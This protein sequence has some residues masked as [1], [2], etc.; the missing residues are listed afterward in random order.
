MIGRTNAVVGE[1]DKKVAI[2]FTVEGA[3]GD[4]ITITDA[5]GEI[6]G[7]VIF[8]TDAVS[9][10]YMM[11][12]LDGSEYTFTSS[13]AKTTD[14]SGGN[15][16]K[17]VTLTQSTA[18]VKVMPDRTFYWKA[19]KNG[20]TEVSKAIAWETLGTYEG[21]I[22][23]SIDETPANSFIAKAVKNTSKAGDSYGAVVVT[24]AIDFSKL[25]TLH[26]LCDASSN[27][28]PSYPYGGINLEVIDSM[29]TKYNRLANAF[30]SGTS[31][32]NFSGVINLNVSSIDGI[33]YIAIAFSSNGTYFQNSTI[34]V[35]QISAE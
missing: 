15:Y 33:G 24:P 19:N 22:A 11:M 17:T 35:K 16:S 32:P 31:R 6:V 34:E 10:E 25:N 1:I 14:G 27:F 13:V 18:E 12:I 21:L 30:I 7:N 20:Y 8:D 23:P 3:K 2:T 26:L 28:S 9:K 5:S 4:N 29:N